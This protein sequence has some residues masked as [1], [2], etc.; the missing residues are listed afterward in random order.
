M[1]VERERADAWLWKN[2]DR[3]GEESTVDIREEYL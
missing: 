2:L 1:K 3:L